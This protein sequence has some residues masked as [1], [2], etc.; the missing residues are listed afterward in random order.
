MQKCAPALPGLD[1]FWELADEEDDDQH[2]LER[3]LAHRLDT[4]KRY[5]LLL[6]RAEIAGDEPAVASLEALRQQQIDCVEELHRALR[7]MAV[8]HAG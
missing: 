5:G 4:L 8:T 3:E 1:L 6:E 7:C 2:P